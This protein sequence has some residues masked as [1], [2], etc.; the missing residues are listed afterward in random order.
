[1]QLL[2]VAYYI[3]EYDNL[4]TSFA[5]K[6]CFKCKKIYSVHLRLLGTIFA[7]EFHLLVLESYLI[8]FITPIR[9]LGRKSFFNLL[10]VSHFIWCVL[11][12]FIKLFRGH[13]DQMHRYT[14]NWK[15]KIIEKKKN[16]T[17]V[18]GEKKKHTLKNY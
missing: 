9:Y 14:H 4:K 6:H 2:L 17:R 16:S 8:I 15:T 10:T 7:N 11:R 13:R 1:M 18:N 5:K 3:Y 12:T